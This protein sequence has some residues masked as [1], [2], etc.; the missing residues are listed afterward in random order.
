[1]WSDENATSL[2]PLLLVCLF[3]TKKLLASICRLVDS[4]LHK[5]LVGLVGPFFSF[6]Q[7]TSHCKRVS[8]AYSFCI[9]KWR[10]CPLLINKAKY[11]RNK[12][13]TCH[14]LIGSIRLIHWRKMWGVRDPHHCLLMFI[15]LWVD[16]LQRSW[17]N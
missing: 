12:C 1:M 2:L 15:F 17:Q 16:K 9:R 6:V 5:L 4:L 13:D 14:V 3:S 10:D 8:F 11:F 7:L